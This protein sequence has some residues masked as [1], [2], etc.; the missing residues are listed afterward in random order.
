MSSSSEQNSDFVAVA[1]CFYILLYL[2]V[3][4]RESIVCGENTNP[5]LDVIFAPPLHDQTFAI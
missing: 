4:Y 5:W 2:T 1:L 3:I